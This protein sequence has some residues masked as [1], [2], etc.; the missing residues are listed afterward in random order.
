MSIK[1]TFLLQQGQ[2]DC[3]VA[4]LVSIIRFHGGNAAVEDVR[5]L[6]GTYL[7]GTTM[8][9]LKQAGEVLGLTV[10]GLKADNVENLA[11]IKLPAILHVTLDEKYQ[12]YIVYYPADSN[13]ARG[14]HSVGDPAH[15]I[16]KMTSDELLAIWKSKAVLTFEPNK[17][18]LL[19]KDLITKKKAW[20]LKFVIDDIKTFSISI[21]L[22]LL[23]SAMGI[24]V[25]IFLQ[26]LIDRILPAKDLYLLPLALGT[27]A[28]V[29][30]SRNALHLLRSFF[31]IKYARNFNNRIIAHFYASLLSLPKSF[32]DSR[33]S[34]EI[35]SRMHDTRKI[36]SVL[37]TG[38][39]NI[40]IDTLLFIISIIF[41]L[42]YSGII[43]LVLLT[44][45]PTFFLIMRSFNKRIFIGQRQAMSGYAAAESHFVDSINGLAEI[46]LT[47]SESFFNRTN[48]TIYGEF[49]NR[50]FA[51]AKLQTAF[52]FFCEITGTVYMISII[53]ICSWM[54]LTQLMTAGE[55]MAIVI[56]CSSA[57]PTLIRLAT[58]NIQLQEALVAF[59]RMFEFTS[60]D[61][62]EKA[63]EKT[64]DNASANVNTITISNVSFR[65][66]GQKQILKELT[67]QF[68]KGEI[69]ALMG[70]SGEGKSTLLQLIQRFYNCESGNI[71]VDGLPID[72]LP[73]KE[74]RTLSSS[75]AQD[76]KIFNTS[77]I[78][79]ITLGHTALHDKQ[80]IDFCEEYGFGNYFKQLPQ[81]YYTL[82]G[83][84]GINLSGGQKQLVNLARAL[85]R[86]PQILLL[87]EATSAMDITTEHFV[88]NLI[89]KMKSKMAIL[90]VTHRIRTAARCDKIIILEGGIIKH[91][92]TPEDL[93]LSDNFFSLSRKESL[94]Q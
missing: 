28:V 34:G 14:E 55:L 92:G 41:V 67:L 26:K 51:L 89:E 90:F 25:S 23:I 16:V 84:D 5:R 94:S 4:C 79:N 17:Q 52:S 88:M 87:D 70:Q 21:F 20:V 69:T 6:S 19:T 80:A 60:L 77:L 47:G 44:A 15:G 45:I 32:F 24:A 12:H 9:G 36:Q 66:P 75:V 39:G 72:K 33:K 10:E 63:D 71:E 53:G 46:K 29:L 11:E 62:E 81:G 65:F 56:A 48:A 50:S 13:A 37:S 76:A 31:L 93:M 40:M 78:H 91:S 30:L 35:I 82:V 68:Q 1:R 42:T 3:G 8:I 27:L 2:A 74:W 43:G 73:L 38:F 57:I 58:S 83:E 64:P 59:D 86:K 85:V 7:Q 18:F 61:S 54:V 22:G 49:Q